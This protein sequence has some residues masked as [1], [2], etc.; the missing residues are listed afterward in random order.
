MRESFVKILSAT[1]NSMKLESTK[2]HVE[3]LKNEINY[4]LAD[5]YAL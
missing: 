1:S 3:K 4:T 5:N 2:I